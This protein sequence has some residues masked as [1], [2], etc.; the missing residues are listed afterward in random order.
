MRRLRPVL[1]AFLVVVFLSTNVLAGSIK[2]FELTYTVD[3]AAARNMLPLINSWR[4]SGD[5][6]YWNDSNSKKIQ[7]GKL[8][9]YTY[10]YNLEQIA[11]QRA[12]EIAVSFSHT[13]PNGSSCFTCVY[14][15]TQTYGE[16]IA[17][18]KSTAKDTFLQF[19]EDNAN[20]AGQGHRRM[21][22]S[23]SFTAIGI[24][25]V[26][27]NG[28]HYWVQEYGYKNSGAAATTA[29]KGTVVGKIEVDTSKINMSGYTTTTPTPTPTAAPTNAPATPTKAPATPNKTPT[30][31]N[32]TPTTPNK[33]PTTPNKTP[34]TPNK[35]PTTPNKTPTTPNKTPTTPNKTPTTPNK[36]PTTPDKTIVTPSK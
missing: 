1:V 9:A 18:G 4:Q 19:R 33:T 25:H 17:Y 36:T 7:C 14:N 21:M 22:A 10:D 13:R 30:T 12:Y 23:S 5:A 24:A 32:K 29:L 16:C 35:T 2:T 8:A 11:L 3:N 26:E 20:Y 28:R 6:W 34:T 27:Y 31:P 15:G